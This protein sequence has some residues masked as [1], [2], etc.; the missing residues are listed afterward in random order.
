MDAAVLR[1]FRIRKVQNARRHA[2]TFRQPRYQCT[3]AT[4]NTND[5]VRPLL[6]QQAL[7]RSGCLEIANFFDI[8]KMHRATHRCI[9]VFELTK[10]VQGAACN[11]EFFAVAQTNPLQRRVFRTAAVD[12]VQCN[13]NFH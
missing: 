1:N 5:S 11:V 6:P 3:G 8:E 12:V 10:T 9:I 13:E 4:R 2:G 7:Q